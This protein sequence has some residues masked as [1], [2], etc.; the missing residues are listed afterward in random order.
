MDKKLISNPEQNRVT[1]LEETLGLAEAAECPLLAESGLLIQ[2]F[3]DDLN[4]RF[5]EKRSF[6]HVRQNPTSE[7]LPGP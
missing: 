6:E 1:R 7:P 5:P 2:Q 3:F 4:D